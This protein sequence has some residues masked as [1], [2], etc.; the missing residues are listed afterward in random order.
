MISLNSQ[1]D[2]LLERLWEELGNFT[3]GEDERMEAPFL[4]FPAGTH[5]ED[6]WHWFDD[7]YSKGVYC[8]MFPSE[9]PSESQL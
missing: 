7:L 5:R 4:H 1:N 3:C 6:I 2:E 8:L 9:T